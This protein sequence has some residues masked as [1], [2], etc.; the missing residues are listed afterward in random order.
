MLN[1]IMGSEK[2]IKLTHFKYYFA[3]S[4]DNLTLFK[5]YFTL[6]INLLYMLTLHVWHHVAA[7]PSFSSSFF[8]FNFF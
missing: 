6:N 4:T 7:D 8:N 5:S 1:T 2:L 3:K